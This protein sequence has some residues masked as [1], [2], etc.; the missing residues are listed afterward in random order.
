MTISDKKS[1]CTFF[2][3]LVFLMTCFCVHEAYG[4]NAWYKTSW[5]MSPDEVRKVMGRQMEVLSD[6]T[7]LM[8][9][10]YDIL[11]EQYDVAFAFDK[12]NELCYVVLNCASSDYGCFLQLEKALKVKYGKPEITKSEKKSGNHQKE[13]KYEWYTKDTY[14][15]LKY[16]ELQDTS[17]KGFKI[18]RYCSATYE[19]RNVDGKF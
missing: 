2:A 14:L 6:G 13:T 3:A 11:G 18:N 1:W 7:T 19:S 16:S 17:S 9:R 12:K 8:L 10:G 15:T 5:G 4:G